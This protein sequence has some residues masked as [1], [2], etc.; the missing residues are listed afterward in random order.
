MLEF[1]NIHEVPSHFVL[2]LLLKNGFCCDIVM[3]QK[4]MGSFPPQGFVLILVKEK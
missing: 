1:T 3:F 2:I 4:G